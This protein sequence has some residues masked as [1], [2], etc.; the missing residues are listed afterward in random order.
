MAS[1]LILLEYDAAIVAARDVIYLYPDYPLPSRWLAAALGRLGQI[2]DARQALEKAI[3]VA[4]A[5]F[6]V[7]VIAHP[8]TGPK[9]T[10]FIRSRGCAR[11]GWLNN[12]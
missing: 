10:I 6:D 9:K 11:P 5:L 12:D 7:S 3:A 8:G 1:V 4:P 2:A